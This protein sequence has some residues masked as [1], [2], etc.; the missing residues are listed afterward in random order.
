M[1]TLAERA[2]RWLL[3]NRRQ[4]LDIRG[5]AFQMKVWYYLMRIPA[6]EVRGISNLVT[7]RDTSRWRLTDAAVAAQ[8]AVLTWIARR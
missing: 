6:G 2:S 8:E 5:T 1:R 4:P 7:N 3:R